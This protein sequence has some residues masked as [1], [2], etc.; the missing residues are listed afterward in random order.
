MFILEKVLCIYDEDQYFQMV[1]VSFK[2]CIM[3]TDT[4]FFNIVL[5]GHSFSFLAHICKVVYK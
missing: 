1:Q 5:K 3:G 2:S 4:E